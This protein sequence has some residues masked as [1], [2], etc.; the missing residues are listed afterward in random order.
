LQPSNYIIEKFF[1]RQNGGV[2]PGSCYIV[3]TYK[4]RILLDEK[5]SIDFEYSKE[6][7]ENKKL[8]IADLGNDKYVFLDWREINAEIKRKSNSRYLLF[9]KPEYINAAHAYLMMKLSIKLK[10]H[11]SEFQIFWDTLKENGSSKPYAKA[12]RRICTATSDFAYDV[13][14]LF[15]EICKEKKIEF[16]INETAGEKQN[17]ALDYAKKNNNTKLCALLIWHGAKENLKQEKGHKVR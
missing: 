5:E 4:V 15:L 12:L 11:E 17:S 14:K 3:N 9:S 2:I 10:G 1:N 6:D 16:D 8:F 7:M 13:T